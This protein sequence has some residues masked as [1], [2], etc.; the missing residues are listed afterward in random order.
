MN[1]T[2][3]RW[4]EFVKTFAPKSDEEM[5]KLYRQELRDRFAMAALTGMLAA[6]NLGEEVADRAFMIV[7]EEAWKQADAMLKARGDE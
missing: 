2:D 1:V 5:A 3:E 6:R 7:A 4:R